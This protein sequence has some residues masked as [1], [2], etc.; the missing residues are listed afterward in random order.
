M[1]RIQ[2]A[3]NNIDRLVKSRPTVL[4]KYIEA[5]AKDPHSELTQSLFTELK[6]IQDMESQKPELL[7]KLEHSISKMSRSMEFGGYTISSEC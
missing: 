3:I 2:N 1:S 4:A 5:K 6:H 7:A